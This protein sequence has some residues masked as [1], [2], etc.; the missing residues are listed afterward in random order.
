MI[1]IEFRVLDAKLNSKRQLKIVLEQKMN[2]NKIVALILCSLLAFSQQAVAQY[3]ILGYYSNAYGGIFG[4]PG[5]YPSFGY[6][7]QYPTLSSYPCYVS[8]YCGS[9]YSFGLGY[10]GGYPY[11]QNSYSKWRV[12]FRYLTVF[13]NSLLIQM[14][15]NVFICRYRFCEQQ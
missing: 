8:V 15:L 10:G 11:F 14:A 12:P 13:S 3:S 1:R 9:G 7:P 2:L 6:Y 4:R 5:G